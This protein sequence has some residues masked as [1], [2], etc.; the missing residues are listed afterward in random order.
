MQDNRNRMQVDRRKHQMR[1][2]KEEEE[3]NANKCPNIVE[4]ILNYCRRELKLNVV[5]F[6]DPSI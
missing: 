6:E 4:N 1:N 5:L 2:T 3:K